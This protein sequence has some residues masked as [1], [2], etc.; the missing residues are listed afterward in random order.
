MKFY[1]A[2]LLKYKSFKERLHAYNDGLKAF[3]GW[4]CHFGQV[5]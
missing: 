1:V 2:Y 5:H 3:S 4:K